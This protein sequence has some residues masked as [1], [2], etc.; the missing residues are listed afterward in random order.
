[1]LVIVVMVW[2][3]HVKDAIKDSATRIVLYCYTASVANYWSDMFDI[4]CLFW[5]SPLTPSITF[6]AGKVGVW[7][8]NAKPDLTNNDAA[9]SQSIFSLIFTT[10]P[11]S[12]TH[13]DKIEIGARM[14]TLFLFS[15][16]PFLLWCQGVIFVTPRMK[17]ILVRTIQSYAVACK[18]SWYLESWKGRKSGSCR[19]RPAQTENG[20]SRHCMGG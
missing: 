17:N 3:N 4:C 15:N 18:V 2:V 8:F 20:S 6:N 19:V 1:M 16:Q 10:A 12:I 11:Y 5:F 14:L 7:Q 9:F 13:F